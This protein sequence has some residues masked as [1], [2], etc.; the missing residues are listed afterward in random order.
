[1]IV[2]LKKEIVVIFLIIILMVILLIFGKNTYA[3]DSDI[4]SYS[5]EE[6]EDFVV[7]TGLSYFYNNTKSDYEQR[8]MDLKETFNCSSFSTNLGRMAILSSQQFNP[9]DNSAAYFC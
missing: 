6:L 9:F 2:K 8:T 1:M 5:R 3:V 7:A 4:K